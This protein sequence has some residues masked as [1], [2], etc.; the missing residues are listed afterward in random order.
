SYSVCCRSATKSRESTLCRSNRWPQVR[1][2]LSLYAQNYRAF[3]VS[4]SEQ[5][6]LTFGSQSA[7][8]G[9]QAGGLNRSHC[10][11]E[12]CS[13][14]HKELPAPWKYCGALFALPASKA[15]LAEVIYDSAAHPGC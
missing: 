2:K 12:K 7:G 1:Q 14:L 9:S 6:V 5:Q 13:S 15:Q 8:R 4:N 11:D 3:Q 10:K